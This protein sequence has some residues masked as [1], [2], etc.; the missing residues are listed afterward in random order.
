[1]SR[2]LVSVASAPMLEMGELRHLE[3][4]GDL[5]ISE[6]IAEAL[7]GLPAAQGN[8][9]VLLTC[10]EDVAVVHPDFWHCTKPKPGIRVVLRLTAQGDDALRSVLTVVISVAAMALGQFWAAAIIPTAGVVQ[11]AVAGLIT[12]GLTVAGTMLLNALI[13]IQ[14]PKER[15]GPGETYA[16]NGWQNTARPG[17]PIPW[18]SG[19]IRTAPDFVGLPYTTIV[20][21][22]QYVTALLCFGYGPL[23]ITD[24]KIGETPIEEFDN[25]ELQLREGVVGDDPVTVFPKQVLEQREGVELTRPKVDGVWED[26]PIIRQTASNALEAALL[27]AFPAGLFNVNDDGETKTISVTVTIEQRLA[28]ASDWD[29]VIELQIRAK[30]RRPFFRQ[31]RWTFPE[32]GRWE[33]RI[34]KLT[35]D[36]EDN[37][38]SRQINLAAIQSFRPE[39]PMNFD[40][41]LALLGIRIKATD[42]LSGQLDSIN[43]VVHR[44]V[45]DWTGDDWQED[46]SRNPASAYRA[47][48]Q[49]PQHPFPVP[50]A[51]ID[52]EQLADWHNFCAAKGLKYDRVH[53]G[54]ES[55]AEMLMAI[56][57][58]GRATPRHDGVRWG[59]V[60]DRPGDT[61]VD[62]ISPRNSSEFRWS[63]SYVDPPDA[64]RVAFQDQ[65]NDW[66]PAERLVPWPGH[67]GPVD[68]VEEL[69][70]PGK[71]DPDEIWIETR[72]RQYEL[73][74]RATSYSALQDAGARVATRGDLLMA[75]YDV[76]DRLQLSARV[77][78]VEGRLVEL[79]G[80]VTMASGVRYGLRFRVFA[81]AQDS[82]GTSVTVELQTHPGARR[83]VMLPSDEQRPQLGHLVHFGV[84]NSESMAVKVRGIEPGTGFSQ[85]IHMLPAA[86]EIDTL[87]DAEVPPA[88]D[89][90]VGDVIDLSAIVPDAPVFGYVDQGPSYS[91]YN[92]DTGTGNQFYDVTVG[93]EPSPGET[94]ALTGYDLEYRIAPDTSWTLVFVPVAAGAY[95]VSDIGH[96]DLVHFRV[97]A[98]AEDGTRSGYATEDVTGG[99]GYTMPGA[100]DDNGISVTGGLGHAE[101]VVAQSS[102]QA[103]L[104]QIY[105]TPA[106]VDLVPTLHAI[107]D[108]VTA[109]P[110]GTYTIVDGDGTRTTSLVN[111]GFD[112]AL[113]W[114]V[115]DG[116]SISAGV[117]TNTP[118]PVGG[119]V[120]QSITGLSGIQRLSFVVSG[121]TAGSVT[122]IL[123]GSGEVTGAPVSVDGPVNQRLDT[124]SGAGITGL[125]LEASADF[126]GSIDDVVMFTETAGCIAAGTYDYYVAPIWGVG[127]SGQIS[128]PFPADIL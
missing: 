44:R 124:S 123:T 72:R 119:R 36:D 5:T 60:I 96:A 61:V 14:P 28:G 105:R 64:F 86:P 3:M 2:A 121:R 78:R 80:E 82:I 58:A 4:R 95:S 52:L 70:L 6:M 102:D 111:G 66:E 31:Y 68:I 76:L 30:K 42:Q 89:S 62:H 12:A 59:V 127:I 41:P 90:S 18:A 120:S 110:G 100:I 87:T 109:T 13:P 83:T 104:L 54:P 32:R 115:S 48:L 73:M 57:S 81:D 46:L 27:F 20:G 126:D 26:R 108:V 65:T 25:V 71:T 128:G 98:V 97:R 74:H 35:N 22:D 34:V 69:P 122:P 49:G 16:I 1:M 38:K 40:K 9:R 101:I 51:E 79:D 21:D 56:C 91:T 63:Q 45:L 118:G 125:A 99:D 113:N 39:Y 47:A 67:E 114:T 112:S 117:A 93:L 15:K 43:A 8:L 92:P 77:T 53:Y 24:V 11:T 19:R 103:E 50:D 33:I 29:P 106:G 55:L 7:P 107:G 23:E 37:R 75:S 116:W 10:G 94:V 17:E 88:W 85:V 84:L